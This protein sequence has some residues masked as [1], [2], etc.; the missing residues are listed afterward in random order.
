MTPQKRLQQLAQAEAQ[1]TCLKCTRTATYKLITQ[2]AGT[3]HYCN[4]HAKINV[5]FADMVAVNHDLEQLAAAEAHH[6]SKGY[7][8]GTR[9]AYEAAVAERNQPSGPLP[10]SY[11]ELLQEVWF[12]RRRVK[13]LEQQNLEYSWQLYPESMGR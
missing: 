7:S 3:H 1:K 10:P 9:E 12:L 6:D 4:Q 13:T 2:F 11:E 5:E 8:I